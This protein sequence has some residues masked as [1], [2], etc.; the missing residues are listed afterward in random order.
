[1]R[2]KEQYELQTFCCCCST[3]F[4]STI[5]RW[6]L[7]VR[8]TSSVVVLFSHH[9]VV[10]MTPSPSSRQTLWPHKPL[11]QRILQT[12]VELMRCL[13]NHM[14]DP[15]RYYNTILSF[16][17]KKHTEY[18][19][20]FIYYLCH[21]FDLESYIIAKKNEVFIDVK[22]SVKKCTFENLIVWCRAIWL[23]SYWWGWC[24]SC[25]GFL[26]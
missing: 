4:S 15:K 26:W 16:K 12:L 20:L 10:K 17:E 2:V 23:R 1:M 22:V 13:A 21:G 25:F 19:N 7:P 3:L 5:E 14:L 8:E 11:R 6:L 9:D 24:S 18:R